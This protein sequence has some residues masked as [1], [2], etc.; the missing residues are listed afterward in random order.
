MKLSNFF[1]SFCLFIG[2][3]V[4]AQSDFYNSDTLIEVR[5]YFQETN[6]DYILDSLFVEGNED[7]L[8]GNLVIDGSSYFNVGV[9]YKGYSSASVNRIKNP[10][11][12]KLD[13]AINDQNHLGHDKIKL[14]NVIQDPSFVREVLSYEI[15]RK[16][17]PAS[18][19]SFA[20]VY[21]N[22]TLIGLYTSVEAVNKNFLINHF[23]TKNNAFFKGNPE[24]LDLNGENANLSNS[25]GT[26]TS[27]YYSLYDLKSNHGWSSLF[28]LIDALNSDPTNI[29]TVLNV[30]RTLWMHAFNYS[31]INFDSY[32]GYAQNY[33]LYQDHNGQFNPI[34]WD[35]NMSFASFRLADASEF[36]DGFS[37]AEA[38][39]MDPLLHHNSVSVYARPLMRNL[40]ENDTYRKMYLAHMRTII[41]ENFDNQEY[42]ARGVQLQALIDTSVFNDTNKFYS[43]TD[44]QDN[45]TSSVSDL[46]DYPGITELMDAR[47]TYL[48]SYIGFSGAPAISNIT[49]S[50]NPTVGGDLTISASI[51]NADEII[52]AY[53]YSSWIYFK[54][55]QCLMMVIMV[56]APMEM[57]FLEQHYQILAIQ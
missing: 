53:R 18:G 36:W 32:V 34:L 9:R 57:E 27:D 10:F 3:N 28:G 45:L 51:T 46:I 30:D 11:N 8:M 13:Y 40:F 19:A 6:W 2:V 14:S 44:F 21:V 50:A 17:M 49:S 29:E 55:Y 35:M 24:S 54:L 41:E 26:D 33:Y 25:P 31:L 12:I 43:Y 38:Q 5:M 4:N 16:Y 23:G 39:T 7:R 20:N 56:M 1:V 48:N 22:D 47:S 52:L 15:A 42:F 37:I